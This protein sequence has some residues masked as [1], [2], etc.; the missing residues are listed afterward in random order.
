MPL[1][2]SKST[3]GTVHPKRVVV[4]VIKTNNVAYLSYN[5]IDRLANSTKCGRCS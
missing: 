4:P 5:M 1:V 3:Q 2:F